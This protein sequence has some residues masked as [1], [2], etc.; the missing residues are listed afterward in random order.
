M[1]EII[2]PKN[3]KIQ[4]QNN[5]KQNYEIKN[6]FVQVFLKAKYRNDFYLGPYS[7]N[8]LGLIHITEEDLM[9]DVQSTY[10]TG[11]MD[12][13]DVKYCYSSI[14]IKAYSKDDFQK[15]IHSRKKELN[16][17]LSGE[18]KKYKSIDE[19]VQYFETAENIKRN[20]KSS[21]ISD[22]WDGRKVEY[23]YTLVVY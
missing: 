14:E 12:Y 3:V 23:E 1:S 15:I 10:D 17:L 19:L 22:H 20:L 6:I 9:N 4:I 21:K 16:M 7:S 11:L 8:S 5:K 2:F 18:K 13:V